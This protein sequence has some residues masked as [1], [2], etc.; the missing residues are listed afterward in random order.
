MEAVKEY[1]GRYSD[2]E[3]QFDPAEY[4]RDATRAGGLSNNVKAML[5]TP[6]EDRTTRDIRVINVSDF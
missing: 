1:S 4:K 6:P 5:R 3:H 2:L